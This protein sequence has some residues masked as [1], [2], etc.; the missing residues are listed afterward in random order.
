MAMGTTRERRRAAVVAVPTPFHDDFSLDLD[1]LRDAE[2]P[3]L[4]APAA[5]VLA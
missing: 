4:G 3:R 5:S 1:A 2:L